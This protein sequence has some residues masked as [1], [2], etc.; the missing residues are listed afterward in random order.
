MS[1]TEARVRLHARL[2]NDVVPI[3][4]CRHAQARILVRENQAVWADGKLILN[5]AIAIKGNRDPHPVLAKCYKGIDHRAK[6]SLESLLVSERLLPVIEAVMGPEHMPRATVNGYGDTILSFDGSVPM[7]PSDDPDCRPLRDTSKV[8]P[9]ASA[10]IEVFGEN[11]VTLYLNR[12]GPCKHGPDVGCSNC[13]RLV[14]G[15]QETFRVSETKM[16]R[17]GPSSDLTLSEAE[18]KAEQEAAEEDCSPPGT[19]HK[20][21]EKRILLPESGG[22]LDVFA[23]E[24]RNVLNTFLNPEGPWLMDLPFP[25]G[26]EPLAEE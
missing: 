9:C 18:Q 7:L 12:S 22:M 20:S 3:A 13:G 1:D 6:Y 17:C 21:S 8:I 2:N 23:F 16:S 10:W 5:D 25:P 19:R 15:T 11:G 24:L 26:T 4:Y 14:D